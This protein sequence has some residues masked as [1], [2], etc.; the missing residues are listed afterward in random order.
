MLV[1]INQY[2]SFKRIPHIDGILPK[3]PIPHAYAWQIGS[4]WQNTLDIEHVQS[5]FIFM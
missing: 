4:F 2:K 3:C 5:R 1:N